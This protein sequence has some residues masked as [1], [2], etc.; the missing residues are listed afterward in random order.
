VSRPRVVL[1]AL[2]SSLALT[3][4][5]LGPVA[6]ASP[7]GAAAD[8]ASA[9]AVEF[10]TVG[11]ATW[12]VPAG[13]CQVEVTLA[14]ASGGSAI[15]P[16]GVGGASVTPAQISNQVIPGGSGA[17]VTG[18]LAVTEGT[19]LSVLVGGVGA[20]W[21]GSA[22]FPFSVTP[23]NGAPEPPQVA[24]GGAGGGGNGGSGL[25]DDGA[26]GGGAS[27][28]A[29]ADGPLAVAG[30]GGGA[31]GFGSG[32]PGGVGGNAGASGADGASGAVP[33]GTSG[34]PAA[35]RATGGGAGT[36]T[37]GGAAGISIAGTFNNNSVAPAQS[38]EL[39]EAT[40]GSSLQG[41]TGGSS[42]DGGGGG[43]GGLF[44]GGGGGAGYFG[45]GAGGGGGSS[46]TPAG[47]SL[48]SGHTGNGVVRIAWTNGTG[49]A[50]EATPVAAPASPRFTG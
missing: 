7:Q 16:M 34:V 3:A 40:A 45:S 49:C 2:A 43:G 11:E 37:A 21:S 50:P 12:T 18:V 4:T 20:D 1:F 14:G 35:Q 13:V 39:V 31:G 8:T 30:G 26:G 38:T 5:A 29:G 27:W 33:L 44:G 17:T 23:A 22:G 24:L 46:L 6:T 32:G 47:G 19:T 15:R 36:A 41:G 28:I 10:T 25:G 9:D 42:G 48:G